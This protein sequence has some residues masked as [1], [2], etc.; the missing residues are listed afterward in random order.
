MNKSKAK[1]A[2]KLS[3]WAVT[4]LVLTF[5]VLPPSDADAQKRLQA[6]V[7]V[8]ASDGDWGATINSNKPIQCTFSSPNGEVRG[9]Y[10]AEIRDFSTA[11]GKS[12]DTVLMWIVSGPSE[13]IGENYEPGGLEGT[14]VSA[15]MDLPNDLEFSANA[16][17]GLGPRS[18]AL[19][20][21]SVQVQTGLSIATGVNAIVLRYIGPIET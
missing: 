10:N 12:G 4:S 19:Q 2:R 3:V 16:L 13:K 11:V 21:I 8:C 15:G 20:P 6:G 18:F 17:V 14:Y 7:L 9:K 5:A 1:C